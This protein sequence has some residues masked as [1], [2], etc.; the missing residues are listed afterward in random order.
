MLIKSI[1]EQLHQ[2]GQNYS[3]ILIKDGEEFQYRL[4][5]GYIKAT[6][7]I[8]QTSDISEFLKEVGKDDIDYETGCLQNGGHLDFAV[9]FD[10]IR[11]RCNLFR[12]GGIGR[13]GMS[14]RKL[15][16]KIPHLDSL[17]LPPLAKA[18]AN[19]ATGLVLCTGAT[20]SGKS[21]TLAAMIDYINETRPGHIIT[22]EDPIEYLQRNKKASVTQRE[23]GEDVSTFAHGLKAALREDPDVILIGEIRDR[24]TCEA[25]LAAAETGH[26]VLST[27]HTTSATKTIERLMDFFHG[28]EKAAMQSVIASVLTGVISQV[29]PPSIDG[30]SRVLVAE[31]MGNFSNIASSIRAGKLQQLPNEMMQGIKDGQTILNKELV[32]FVNQGLITKEVARS[33]AYDPFGFDQELQHSKRGA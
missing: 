26:L 31:V 25:A 29:L 6:E 13:L 33:S 19:R 21:T 11:Y 2:A 20:G 17:P 3:D 16:D 9:T 23:V 14:M 28:D 7:D 12:F 24:E 15:N 4:P 1:F 30:K 32:K 27:L 10:N 22:L 8:I 5:S 18:F